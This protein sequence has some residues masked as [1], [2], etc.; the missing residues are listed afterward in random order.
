MVALRRESERDDGRR[1]AEKLRVIEQPAR[2]DTLPEHAS[3]R[4]TG[5][6]LA[7]SCLRCPLE[8]CKYDEPGGAR[9]LLTEVRDREIVVLRRRHAAP[10]S[11]LADHYGLTR[12]SIFR[13]LKGMR[14]VA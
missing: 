12:R 6:E 5:C 8:R 3:Y 2:E 1:R 10:I 9:R 7:P 14:D 11:M 13:I 4:D